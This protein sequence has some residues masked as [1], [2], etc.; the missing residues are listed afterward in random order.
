M[1]CRRVDKTFLVLLL[2][3]VRPPLAG[4]DRT[5]REQSRP[6][7]MQ[8]HLNKT[9]LN[10]FSQVRVLQVIGHTHP[11]DSKS[12]ASAVVKCV[13][14]HFMYEVQH[15]C[16]QPTADHFHKPAFLRLSWQKQHHFR[17]LPT[18][19][20]LLPHQLHPAAFPR[21]SPCRSRWQLEQDSHPELAAALY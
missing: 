1:N 16:F 21:P 3:S 13:M 17:L 20:G 5:C 15:R 6:R 2:A 14:T 11:R 10:C 4:P 12:G 18:C 9:Q 19:L 8:A 7:T